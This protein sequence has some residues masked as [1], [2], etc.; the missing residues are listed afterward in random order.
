MLFLAFL[1]RVRKNFNWSFMLKASLAWLFFCLALT[2]SHPEFFTRAPIFEQLFFKSYLSILSPLLAVFGLFALLKKVKNRSDF[3]AALSLFLAMFLV[4]RLWLGWLSLSPYLEP[5]AET[6]ALLVSA[7]LSLVFFIWRFSFRFFDL[8]KLSNRFYLSLLFC[9]LESSREY[10]FCGFPWYPLGFSF[11]KLAPEI[12]AYTGSFGASFLIVML[13]LELVF[14][15]RLQQKV[16]ALG[17]F[18]AFVFLLPLFELPQEA[19]FLLQSAIVHSKLPVHHFHVS[20]SSKQILDFLNESL[21]QL[22]KQMR[23]VRLI[24]MPEG[25]FPD[26]GSYFLQH[27]GE[28]VYKTNGRMANL[29][30]RFQGYLIMGVE[31][32]WTSRE[33]IYNS[34]WVFGPDGKLVCR[35]AK[36]IL[37]PF[38]EY[39]PMRNWPFIGSFAASLARSYGILD[40][41]DEGIGGGL[42]ELST[43]DKADSV[44]TALT[45]CFEETFPSHVLKLRRQGAKLWL[46]LSNDGWYP[47]SSLDDEHAIHARMLAAS[48]GLPLLRSTQL[49][50]TGVVDG[51]GRWRAI[52]QDKLSAPISYLP[53]QGELVAYKT[54]FTFWGHYLF[55]C[56][57]LVQTFYILYHLSP[58]SQ[59]KEKKLL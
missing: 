11:L 8:N 15:R 5:L 37:I 2:C 59:K 54:P 18:F 46:S 38:A 32:D 31:D 56:P 7:L 27:E 50:K 1:G 40:A 4:Y 58:L 26:S 41:L 17:C 48:L 45:I 51:K 57:W 30:K 9:V 12:Y 6:A 24:L 36:H 43:G 49:G 23:A 3:A 29:A 52:N 39:F 42:V 19:P 22:D 47:G 20:Y 33:H 53:W 55:I 28:V 34:A 21:P 35:Y 14:A 13:S 10:W 44:Q 16:V 25:F